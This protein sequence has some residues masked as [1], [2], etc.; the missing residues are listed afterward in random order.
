MNSVLPWYVLLLPLISAAVTIV[1]LTQTVWPKSSSYRFG[2]RR[3]HRVHLQLRRFSLTSS[4]SAARVTGSISDPLLY[5]PLGF[6]LD[7]LSKTMLVLVTGIGA[8][9][10]IYSL[11]YMSD[12]AASRATSLPLLLHV[13]DAWDRALEQLRH[14]VHLL[15]T[16]RRQFLFAHRPLVRTRRRRRAAANKAFLTNR[17]GDF[18]FMLGILMVW[19]ATGSVVFQ[20]IAG[21][22]GRRSRLIPDYLADRSAADFLRRGRE[23]RAIPAARLV[24]G[25]DGRSDTHLRADPCR[26]DGGGGSLHAR[27][28]RLSHPGR[29]AGTHRSSRGSGPSPR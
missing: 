16:G 13:L 20:E 8:L 27:A 19:T 11:G 1:L 28:R 9:I 18:G 6:V 5:V 3:G 14:D 21:Q 24:A 29:A 7:D 15:G 22:M 25:R 4:T 23:I 10:H 12:D 2:R 26:D 17:I